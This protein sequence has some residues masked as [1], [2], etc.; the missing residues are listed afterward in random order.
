MNTLIPLIALFL[1]QAAD[2]DQAQ[3]SLPAVDGMLA[4][5]RP[6]RPRVLASQED[7][8]RVA[9]LIRSDNRG[10]LATNRS[11]F[12]RSRTVL[13]LCR[14]HLTTSGGAWAGPITSSSPFQK[15][16]QSFCASAGL[17]FFPASVTRW[18]SS[19]VFLKRRLAWLK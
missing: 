16:S 12:L 1:I 7:F 2:A 3:L 8:D 13:T 9:Q 11:V 5:S 10:Y 14:Y 4:D 15:R 18:A 6:A 17:S 19:G